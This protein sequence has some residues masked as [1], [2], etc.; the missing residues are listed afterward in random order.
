MRRIIIVLALLVCGLMLATPP[1]CSALVTGDGTITFTFITNPNLTQEGASFTVGDSPGSYTYGTL[2]GANGTVTDGHSTS[3]VSG[4]VNMVYNVPGPTNSFSFSAQ[5][6]SAGIIGVAQADIWGYHMYGGVWYGPNISILPA[7][8]YTYTLNGH[9]DSSNDEIG[10][11]TQLE[12]SYQ[13]PVTGLYT[14]PYSDYDTTVPG[15]RDQMVWLKDPDLYGNLSQSGT[16]SFGPF[17]AGKDV[18]WFISWDFMGTGYDQL[19]GGENPVPI[20]GSILLFAPGLA[21]IAL[22]RRRLKK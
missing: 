18:Q 20:P 6:P 7:F 17:D 22:L 15:F 1:P 13:D 8:S 21:G 11:I 14:K 16:V 9:V 10:L 5:A 3:S 19:P 4:I 2:S 12:V